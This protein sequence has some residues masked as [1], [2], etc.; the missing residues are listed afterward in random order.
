MKKVI[1]LT[2]CLLVVSCNNSTEHVKPQNKGKYLLI[3]EREFKIVT[4]S[5]GHEYFT[6][7]WSHGATFEHLVDCKFC[8]KRKN[9]E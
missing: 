5:D 8:A 1:I 3:D 4:G 9:N 2:V 7:Y 6:H